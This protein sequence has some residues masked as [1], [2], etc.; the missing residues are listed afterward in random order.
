MVDA[1]LAASVLDH[2]VIGAF[3]VSAPELVRIDIDL[4]STPTE[5]SIDDTII[6]S[7][8]QPPSLS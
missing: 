5:E 7:S 3:G 2:F 6:S 4:E 1:I 8:D